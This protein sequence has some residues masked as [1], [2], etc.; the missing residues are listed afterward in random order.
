MRAYP[1]GIPPLVDTVTSA[2]TALSASFI[3]STINTAGIALNWFG[4]SGSTGPNTTVYGSQG[5]QGPVG[6]TGAKGLGV[7]LLSS[8]LA[9]CI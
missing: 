5:P 6:P 9:T 4:P 1:F 7:Y 3:N 8:S 2:S